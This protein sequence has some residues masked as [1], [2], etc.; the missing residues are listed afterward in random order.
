LGCSI[1][2]FLSFSL[3]SLRC[4]DDGE[5]PLLKFPDGK[6]RGVIT[7][8]KPEYRQAIEARVNTIQVLKNPMLVSAPTPKSLEASQPLPSLPASSS[9]SSGSE[10][11]ESSKDTKPVKKAMV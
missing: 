10:S 4:L 6:P 3:F 8:L 1:L 11:A 2:T 9:S 7:F 5:F